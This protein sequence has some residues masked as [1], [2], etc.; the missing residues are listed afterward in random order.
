MLSMLPLPMQDAAQVYRYP[1]GPVFGTRGRIRVDRFSPELL[2]A[3]PLQR[4]RMGTFTT[5]LTTELPS[6]A[7]EDASIGPVLVDVSSAG[8]LTMRWIWRSWWIHLRLFGCRALGTCKIERVRTHDR[9]LVEDRAIISCEWEPGTV[10]LRHVAR[11]GGGAP[12]TPNSFTLQFE[13]SI[14]PA[15]LFALLRS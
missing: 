2:P 4:F 14:G 6:V 1:H 5:R 11:Y 15:E 12:E 10:P 9:I 13:E 3:E 7:V 8:D